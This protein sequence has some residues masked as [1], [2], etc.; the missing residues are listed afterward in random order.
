MELWDVYNADRELTGRTHTRGEPMQPGDYHLV[1]HVWVVNSRGEFFIDL[2]APEKDWLPNVWETCGGSAL[3]GDDSL[4]AA[5]REFLE[6][7]GIALQPEAGECVISYRR[8]GNPHNEYGGDFVDVWLFRQDID[9]ADFV[10]QPGETVQAK[11]A[12]AEEIR[13][14]MDDGTFPPYSYEKELFNIAGSAA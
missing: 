3:V 1:V 14:M 6:E 5:L 13:R 9:P 10:P 7:T 2:R 4:T 12:T 8:E 11:L